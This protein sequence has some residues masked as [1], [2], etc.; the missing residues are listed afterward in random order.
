MQSSSVGCD[1]SFPS[2][3]PQLRSPTESPAT[4]PIK[5]SAV[6]KAQNQSMWAAVCFVVTTGQIRTRV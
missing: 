6:K 2:H 4:K 1:G 5:R 3:A